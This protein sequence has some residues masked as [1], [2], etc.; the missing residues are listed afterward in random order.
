MFT[1]LI[2]HTGTLRRATLADV[3]VLSQ[4][5]ARAGSD[6]LP[7][8]DAELATMIERGHLLVFDVGAGALGA[9]AHVE[10]SEAG[11]ARRGVFRYLAV[12]PALV[13][14]D[15][16]YR[17]MS[18]MRHRCDGLDLAVFDAQS[19]SRELVHAPCGGLA[20]RFAYLTMALL[21]L[22]RV[23]VSMGH[24]DAAVAALVWSALALLTAARTPHIPRAIVHRRGHRAGGVISATRLSRT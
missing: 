17:L 23:L 14:P 4:L 10:P 21:A 24:N 8:A 15:L 6:N 5:L 13:G 11:S 3:P 16:R 9:A 22:P 12:D 18:A 19:P 20:R 7:V 2:P 1:P